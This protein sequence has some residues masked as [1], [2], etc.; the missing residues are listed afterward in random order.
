MHFFKTNKTKTSG[1]FFLCFLL[2]FH[3]VS[4]AATMDISFKEKVIITDETIHLDDIAEFGTNNN[5]DN[6]TRKLTITVAP[7]PGDSITLQTSAI[8]NFLQRNLTVEKINWKGPHSIQ[9]IR[10]GILI[11]K[12]RFQQILATYLSQ[13]LDKLPKAEFRFASLRTPKPFILPTGNLTW[14]VIPSKPQIIGSSSF[15]IIFKQDGKTIK[16]STISGRLEALAEVVS[17][18]VKLK[19]GT[20]ITPNQLRL[21]KQNLVHL[22]NPF[23]DKSDLV[24]MRTKRTILPGRVIDKQHIESLPMINKGELVK[25]SVKTGTMQLTTSGIA[26]MDGRQG[27]IIRVEN[28]NSRKLIYC[29][30]NGPGI[31]TVEF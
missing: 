30:V 28:I 3:S 22:H 21:S 11:D 17:A 6:K 4:L 27:D 10:D 2:L 23:F 8:V 18:A 12:N 15:S 5:I 7:K 13:N 19:K 25:I 14:E 16:S 26:K 20:T 29:R 24:G 9:I 1:L 31:V